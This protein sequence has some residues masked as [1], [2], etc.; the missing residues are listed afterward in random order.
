MNSPSKPTV[1]YTNTSSTP[2]RLLRHLVFYTISSSAIT[3]HLHQH[4][5]STTSSFPSSGQY[6]IL[7]MPLVCACLCV[8]ARVYLQCSQ[9]WPICISARLFALK[10]ITIHSKLFSN[11]LLPRTL[12]K[13]LS[14]SIEAESRQERP[15]YRQLRRV[16]RLIPNMHRI[17]IHT[18]YC[19]PN[20]IP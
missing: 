1:L 8:S 11:P 13:R 19:K 18:G 10:S 7:S 6:S 4:F 16:H 12:P 2:S 17:A 14:F 3:H 5:G 15:V 9:C 20:T